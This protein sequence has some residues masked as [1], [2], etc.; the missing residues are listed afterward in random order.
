MDSTTRIDLQK[1]QDLDMA[2]PMVTVDL[3]PASSAITSAAG[4]DRATE[5]GVDATRR[6]AAVAE[7]GI[8]FVVEEC[9]R[10]LRMLRRVFFMLRRNAV[11]IPEASDGKRKA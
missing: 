5:R 8:L 6:R 4:P 10:H 9:V 11:R 7:G 2:T 1:S 3:C